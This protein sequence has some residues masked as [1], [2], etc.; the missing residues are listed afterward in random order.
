MSIL[1]WPLTER[2]REK[3]ISQGAKSLSDAEL[4]AILIRTGIK[5]KTALDIARELL[6][7]FGNLKLIMQADY[8]N[9]ISHE[10]IGQQTYALFQA[11]RELGQRYYEAT[12]REAPVLASSQDTLHFIRAKLG[13][14]KHEVVACLCLDIQYRLICFTELFHG[15]LDQASVYP[16]ELVSHA[17]KHNACA[18]ILC[19]NHPSGTATPSPQDLSLTV[20]LKK[21][22]QLVEIDLVDHI[23]V[24]ENEAYSCAENGQM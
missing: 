23:I 4:L 15:T 11:T 14:Y 13:D 8:E 16:R 10:G 6:T 2:P 3:L 24:G 17:L 5:G 1:D 12:L 18:I 7:S 19:H 20:I 22:L 9:L 21:A